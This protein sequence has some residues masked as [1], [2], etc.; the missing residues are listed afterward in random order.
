MPTTVSHAQF[1]VPTALSESPPLMLQQRALVMKDVS[2]IIYQKLVKSIGTEYDY[3]TKIA[4]PS[5]SGYASVLNPS[6]VS[7]S[8]LTRDQLVRKQQE[9]IMDAYPNYR[10]SI[11]HMFE[12]VNGEVNKRFREAVDAKNEVYSIQMGKVLAFTGAMAELGAGVV[13]IASFWMTGDPTVI[14][15]LR[16]DDHIISG[17][18]VNV[19]I[20]R[21]TLKS[22]LVQR[23][24]QSGRILVQTDWDAAVMA[25]ENDKNN[26][27]IKGLQLPA[28]T[29]F[30]TGGASHCD[31]I[32]VDGRKYLEVKVSTV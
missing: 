30:I 17:G 27:I 16:G 8:D 10:T 28:Y 13:G 19:T 1:M 14:R 6:F 9:K 20:S 3:K 11:D 32:I 18:P 29:P 7:R 4:G 5:A 25:S 22:A 31:W 23:L 26:A 24:I 15:H 2:E 21:P 12:T